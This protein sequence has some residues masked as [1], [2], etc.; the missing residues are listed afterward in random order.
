M[1]LSPE[2]LNLNLKLEG[3]GLGD[4]DDGQSN[5][6]TCHALSRIMSQNLICP[7]HFNMSK[8]PPNEL[9]SK[10]HQAALSAPKQVRGGQHALICQIHLALGIN[11]QAS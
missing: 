6:I 5:L 4:V 11:E 3:S 9:E 2:S 7:S 1:L 8:R 10:L